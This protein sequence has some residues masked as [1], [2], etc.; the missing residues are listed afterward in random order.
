MSICFARAHAEKD[1]ILNVFFCNIQFGLISEYFRTLIFDKV[2]VSEVCM[3]PKG[4]IR[5]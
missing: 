1:W 4:V 3:T 2:M 5:A